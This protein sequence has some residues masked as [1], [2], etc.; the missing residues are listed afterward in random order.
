[1]IQAEQ[2]TLATHKPFSVDHRILTPGGEI[3]TVN[4][5]AEVLLDDKGKPLRLLGTVLDI[6]QRKRAEN[7]ERGVL[8][9]RAA[10]EFRHHGG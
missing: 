9:A 7:R 8:Q 10:A 6:T 1:M 5:Q 4:Q 2:E 3:K